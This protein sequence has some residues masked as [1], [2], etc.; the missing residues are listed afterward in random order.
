MSALMGTALPVLVMAAMVVVGLELTPADLARVLR[1]PA[2]VV[3]GL[4]AQVL[5]LPL[6]GAAL[7]MLLRPDPAVA[8]GLLLVAV[9]PQATASNLYC[10]VARADIALTVTLTAVS[11]AVALLST[12]VLAAM[13]F[14]LLLDPAAGIRLPVGPVAWQA[15]SGL[16]MPIALGMA[17]RA[18]APR[19]VARWRGPVRWASLGALGLLLVV[20]LVGARAPIARHFRV[21]VLA[22]TLFT[23]AA[24][25]AGFLLSRALSWPRDS[26]V[27]MVAAFPARSLSLATLVAVNVL[28]RV[29][30]LS[31]AV[32]FLVVQTAL[33]LPVMLLA[34]SPVGEVRSR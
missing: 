33:L 32:V 21:I 34:R 13:L 26:A 3:V 27:T 6:I 11:S 8:G 9:A 18:R 14:R 16:L 23:V 10:L 28:G 7:V 22:A 29:D 1:Y 12:P 15:L 30:F 5:V 2:Q 19:F 4:L 20:L 24:A 17:L 31:F 25:G